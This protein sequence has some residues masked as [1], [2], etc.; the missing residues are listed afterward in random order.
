MSYVPYLSVAFKYSLQRLDQA[1]ANIMGPLEY[2]AASAW[3]KV[4]DINLDKCPVSR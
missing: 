2:E 1:S 3:R 4:L